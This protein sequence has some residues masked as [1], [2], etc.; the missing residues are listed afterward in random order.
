MPFT[1]FHLGPGVLAKSL[2]G[3]R[4]SFMVFGG[5][6]VLMD[7]EALVRIYRNDAILHGPSHTVAGAVLIGL[8]AG[9]LGRPVSLFVLETLRITHHDIS[10][11]VSFSTA[12]LGTCS[13]IALDAIMHAD[14]N[15]LFPFA[16]GNGLLSFFS[17]AELH[18][19]CLIT[20]LL[21]CGVLFLRAAIGGWKQQQTKGP[22]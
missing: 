17:V 16:Q 22:N 18:A 19:L 9:F 4:F 11:R 13:H 2:L 12:F 8:A 21:G 5:S 1:P 15:A 7:V 20:G 3:P 6:Q 10:W 14:M